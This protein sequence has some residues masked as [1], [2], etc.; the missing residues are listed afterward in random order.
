[1]LRAEQRS[2]PLSA[3]ACVRCV[4]LSSVWSSVNCAGNASFCQTC[5][6]AA[7]TLQQGGAFDGF[8]L[9]IGNAEAHLEY[10]FWTG[11][12]QLFPDAC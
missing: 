10:P 1:M 12:R 7:A 4:V 11:Q 6:Q 5:G 3:R 2:L 8:S 9:V